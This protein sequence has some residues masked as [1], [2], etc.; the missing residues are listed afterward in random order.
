[1]ISYSQFSSI[2]IPY[3]RLFKEQQKVA[4]C[5]SSIDELIDAESRKLEALKTQ[6]KG[7]MQKLFPVK[8][9]TLPVKII[10]A[11]LHMPLK[12]EYSIP[13]WNDLRLIIKSPTSTTL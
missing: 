7:L 9:K 4:D 13:P 10:Y 3:P 2:K 1:M 5:L 8:G 12:R 6:K 11:G